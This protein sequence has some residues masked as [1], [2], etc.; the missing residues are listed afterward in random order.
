MSFFF[1]KSLEDIFNDYPLG[2][3]C[4]KKTSTLQVINSHWCLFSFIIIII[5]LESRIREKHTTSR[6][7]GT[8]KTFMLR[9]IK[10]FK[11]IFDFFFLSSAAVFS[12]FP[13]QNC[14]L[15]EM[16]RNEWGKVFFSAIFYVYKNHSRFQISSLYHVSREQALLPSETEN[17]VE[18]TFTYSAKSLRWIAWMML[19]CS[20]DF[21]I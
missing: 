18:M 9:E 21:E 4:Q 17:V 5:I 8:E 13:Q 6:E 14:S 1:F 7:R 3:L 20:W 16:G 19:M 12:H 2:Y 10:K 15:A 11:L